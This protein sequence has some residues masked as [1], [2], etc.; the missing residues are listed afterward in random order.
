MPPNGPEEWRAR[1]GQ[2]ENRKL[3]WYQAHCKSRPSVTLHLGRMVLEVPLFCVL[4]LLLLTLKVVT[5]VCERGNNALFTLGKLFN[6]ARCCK[7]RVWT[8]SF[9]LLLSL[10]LLLMM[11]GDVETNPGPVSGEQKK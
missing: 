10:S 4:L 2:W 11:A 5:D 6:H 1:I 9:T 8:T 7:I 3:R